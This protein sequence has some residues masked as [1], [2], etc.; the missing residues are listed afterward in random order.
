MN[1]FEVYADD[2]DQWFDS[3]G[4]RSIFLDEVSCVRELIPEVKGRWL[5]IGVG[6]GRFAEAL[7]IQ[8][9]VD[10]SRAVLRL[11][12][13]RGV[14]TCRARGEALPYP[15]CTFDGLLMVMTICFL[16]DPQRT[17]RECFRVLKSDR[18]LIVGFVPADS[19]WG[20]AYARK[21]RKGHRFYHAA[22]FCTREQVVGFATKAGFVLREARGCL[23]GPPSEPLS[24][25]C[26]GKESFAEAG[27]MALKFLRSGWPA[28]HDVP[29]ATS[30]G[31]PEACESR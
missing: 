4:G 8:E 1:P 31:S 7:G 28:T 19:P 14:R 2:Y 17:L 3:P 6:T 29:A 18:S 30:S 5:E 16:S 25:A 11:A 9:G 23:F 24:R 15:D 21:A 22:S 26:P 13:K 27:F 12:A 10:P 20:R